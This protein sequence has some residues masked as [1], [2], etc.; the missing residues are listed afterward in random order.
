MEDYVFQIIRVLSGFELGY[1]LLMGFQLRLQ[2]LEI[3]LWRIKTRQLHNT[4]SQ[5]LGTL[6][7]LLQRLDQQLAAPY[8][9]QQLLSLPSMLNQ[10]RA[11]LGLCLFVLV[12]IPIE[13][14]LEI[15]ADSVLQLGSSLVLL[16]PCPLEVE[17]QVLRLLHNPHIL[18]PHASP[19]VDLIMEFLIQALVQCSVDG[20]EEEAQEL[21][22]LCLGFLSLSGYLDL[23]PEQDIVEFWNG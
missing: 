19:I 8:L 20:I 21:G 3:P 13:I 16:E 1:G 15:E 17:E 5:M 22:L 11:L 23:S 10:R 14:D 9:L 12:Q 18:L 7:A 6:M 2:G 4:L